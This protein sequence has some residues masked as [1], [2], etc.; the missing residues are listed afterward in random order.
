MP[1]AIRSKGRRP[2]TRKN[3]ADFDDILLQSSIGYQVRQTNR[4]SESYIQR[5][6]A[7]HDVQVGMWYLLR[8]LWIEDGLTQRELSRRVGISEPTTLE[9][10][11]KMEKSGLIVRHRDAADGRK[12]IVSLSAEGSRLKDNLLKYVYEMNEVAFCNFTKKDI[13]LLK[14]LLGKVRRNFRE[15]S[16]LKTKCSKA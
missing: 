11:R 12:T 5:K 9:Q 7:P 6:L 1:K 2:D 13:K 10:L 15:H 16:L 8:T 4:M 3:N 14:Q